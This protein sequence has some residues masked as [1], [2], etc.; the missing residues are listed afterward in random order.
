MREKLFSIRASASTTIGS[1]SK[2]GTLSSGK[3]TASNRVTYVVSSWELSVLL[4][5]GGCMVQRY[6]PC[7]LSRGQGAAV[8]LLNS[9]YEGLANRSR[10]LHR[11]PPCR[12]TG[13]GRPRR[14]SDRHLQLA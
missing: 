12:R 3:C 1:R 10:W 11:I 8:V 7:A 13:E 2:D 14:Q 4:N 5:A 6:R 9:P